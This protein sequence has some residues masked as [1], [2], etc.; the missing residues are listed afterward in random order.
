[1]DYYY[2]AHSL[3]PVIS[4]FT[5]VSEEMSRVCVVRI[6]SIN[7]KTCRDLAAQDRGSPP[8]PSGDDAFTLE[9]VTVKQEKPE[10]ERD[11]SV[12]CLDSIKVEDF[13]P[14]CMSA[15]Q[16]KMLEEWKPEELDIQSQDSNTPLSCIGLAQ[17]KEGKQ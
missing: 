12:C 11:G 6:E 7:H 3:Y 8:L 2:I 14:E 1:M 13:S 5:E 4:L 15:A 16:S 17:G 10:E 9:Q